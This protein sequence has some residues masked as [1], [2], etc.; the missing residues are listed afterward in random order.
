MKKGEKNVSTILLIKYP[1]KQRPKILKYRFII[2]LN[3]TS[4]FKNNNLNKLTE[5]LFA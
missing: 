5:Q 1:P 3:L 2:S 4:F